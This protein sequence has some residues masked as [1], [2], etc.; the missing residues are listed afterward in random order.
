MSREPSLRERGRRYALRRVEQVLPRTPAGDRWFAVLEFLAAHGRLPERRP[1]RYSDHL[2]SL[3]AGGRL[4]D[5]LRRFVT[6][7]E[8]VKT[9][10]AAAVGERF[11]LATYRILRTP[12]EASS[13]RPERFPCV[14]K[15][16]HAAG[17]FRICREP[18]DAPPPE[19]LLGWLADDFY[20][21]GREGNYR[22]LRRQILVEEFF[23]ADG[24]VPAP[25]YKVYCFGGRARFVQVETGRG[26]DA[27]LRTLRDCPS[28]N[29]LPAGIRYPPP[30][31]PD[32][33]GQRSLSR[34]PG[35]TPVAA[36]TRRAAGR[37]VRLPAGG[38]LRHGHRGSGRRVD[39][40]SEPGL[41]AG[42]SAVRPV[43]PRPVLRRAGGPVRTPGAGA[44]GAAAFPPGVKRK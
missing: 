20:R 17:R 11:N 23:S 22:G 35:A 25:E 4:D 41:L 27:Y 15:P 21:N 10:I 8:S 19:T 1:K 43:P 40:L 24:K 7:K 12:E 33:D 36:G 29:R 9:Y 32:A 38:P 18:A 13:F 26:T 30:P 16:T 37:P 39:E 6:C 42:P 31:P 14:V 5:P 44:E 2:F 34:S 28:W 3:R